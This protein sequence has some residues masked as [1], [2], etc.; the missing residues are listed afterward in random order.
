M[1][2][3]ECVR[4]MLALAAAGALD[5]A[6]SMRVERH[7]NACQDCRRELDAWRT[8]AQGLRQLPQPSAPADLMERTRALILDQRAANERAVAAGRCGNDLMLG[9]LA[10]FGWATGLT[11]WIL[12]RVFTGGVVSVPGANLVNGW[13]WFMLSTVVVWMTAA[14]AAVM[15]GRGRQIRRVL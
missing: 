3:H 12:A 10:V 14:T 9:A 7:A 6:E 4:A 8:Y 1:S 11:F 13:T 15:L 2:E 5:P